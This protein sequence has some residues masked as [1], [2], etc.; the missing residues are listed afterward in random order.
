[1]WGPADNTN[2]GEWDATTAEFHDVRPY[3]HGRDLKDLHVIDVHHIHFEYRP[4]GSGQVDY[5]TVLRN[6]RDYRFDVV[7]SLST[8][9]RTQSGSREEAMRINYA[10]A[11]LQSLMREF[12]IGG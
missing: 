8:H 4:I 9:F 12:E 6:L 3:L 7:L 2:C 10:N 5:R 1:M 11:N